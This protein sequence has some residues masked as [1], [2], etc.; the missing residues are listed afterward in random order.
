MPEEETAAISE[1]VGYV[2]TLPGTVA[3]G[4]VSVTAPGRY[5][6]TCV[7]HQGSD[8]DRFEALGVDP[9]QIDPEADPST[10]APGVAELLAEIESNP[11]HQDLGML[12]EFTVTEAGTEVGPLPEAATE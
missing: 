9:Q 4:S 2:A 7:I 5:I 12:Q 10:L 8:P 3:E 6:V 1:F 11:E